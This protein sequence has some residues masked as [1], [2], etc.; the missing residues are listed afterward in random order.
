M[1]FH[2]RKDSILTFNEAKESF[3]K[4]MPEQTKGYVMDINSKIAKFL[5]SGEESLTVRVSSATI[6]GILVREYTDAGWDV[7]ESDNEVTIDLKP[8]NK[9]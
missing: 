3:E 6:R 8:I 7:T 5:R 9:I 1:Q 4:A 2:I